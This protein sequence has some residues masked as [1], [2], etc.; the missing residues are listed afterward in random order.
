MIGQL[1]WVLWFNTNAHMIELGEF[2][3]HDSCRKAGS[4]YVNSLVDIRVAGAISY[5]C[6]PVRKLITE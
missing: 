5:S 6:W 4:W 1:V 2:S 3:D